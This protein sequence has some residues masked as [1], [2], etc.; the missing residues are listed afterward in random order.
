ME[1]KLDEMTIPEVIELCG[2]VQFSHEKTVSLLSNRLNKQ[3]QA[4][5]HSDL[6]TYGTEAFNI[7]QV[8]TPA[9][10]S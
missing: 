6:S 10:W 9:S 8:Y 2:R 7:P 5:L 1:K 4:Q 3:Q